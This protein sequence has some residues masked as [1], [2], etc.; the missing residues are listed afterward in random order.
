MGGSYSQMS[1]YTSRNQSFATPTKNRVTSK[2]KRRPLQQSYQYCH[3]Q[4]MQMSKEESPS[5]YDDASNEQT[6][7]DTIM[8]LKKNLQGIDLQF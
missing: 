6:I 1:N 2:R 7:S 4:L 3:Q 5:V 8:L